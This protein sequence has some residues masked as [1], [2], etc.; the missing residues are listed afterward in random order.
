MVTRNIQVTAREDPA[1]NGDAMDTS[2]EAG[3][4]EAIHTSQAA[5]SGLAEDEADEY[6]VSAATASRKQSV[7]RDVSATVEAVAAAVQ[8]SEAALAEKQTK[9]WRARL[10]LPALKKRKKRREVT[11]QCDVELPALDKDCCVEP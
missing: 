1:T 2:V 10:N 4:E 3:A 11:L 6:D 8:E 7:S 5:A 9:R